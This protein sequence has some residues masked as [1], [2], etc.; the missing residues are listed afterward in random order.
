[1]AIEDK[2]QLDL[3]PAELADP[4]TG[5]ARFAATGVLAVT[6]DPPPL[7]KDQLKD[8]WA[9]GMTAPEVWI[10][11]MRATLQEIESKEV[12][13]MLL[14]AIPSFG[15][16]VL[17]QPFWHS[18]VA[19]WPPEQMKH[20]N[21]PCNAETTVL[22]MK[23]LHGSS[24]SRIYRAILRISPERYGG[25]SPCAVRTKGQ[26]ALNEAHETLFHEL[27]HALRMVSQNRDTTTLA[28][29]LK[30]FVMVEEF[31]AVVVTNIYASA[32]G[33]TGLRGAELGH[34]ALPQ[35]F[36]DSF[37]FFEMGGRTFPII[38]QL[39]TDNADFCKAL[40][41]SRAN[42]NPIAAFLTDPDKARRCSESAKARARDA[43]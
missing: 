27:V 24:A 30:G 34:G 6:G 13:G 33:K 1:M 7:T 26:D 23:G 21:N 31:I 29:G 10:E 18:P 35:E 16:W 11:K 8:P 37:K 39:C 2:Y 4:A 9:G 36:M 17:V 15:A 19:M 12:G 38:K 3:D 22:N 42:H 25:Q 40:K 5:V 20:L 28:G 14:R 32:N 41:T 43:H